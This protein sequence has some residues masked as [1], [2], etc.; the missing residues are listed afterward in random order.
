MSEPRSRATSIVRDAILGAALAFGGFH[1]VIAVWG[2]V[3]AHVSLPMFRWLS[4][5]GYLQRGDSLNHFV[6]SVPDALA[7][8]GV[9]VGLA[10]IVSRFSRADWWVAAGTFVAVLSLTAIDWSFQTEHPLFVFAHWLFWAFLLP[11]VVVLFVL[12]HPRKRD[13][14]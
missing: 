7:V 6:M 14:V 4:L 13:A 11:A 12:S 1:L 10:A 3:A 8:I 5:G 9:S 2:F